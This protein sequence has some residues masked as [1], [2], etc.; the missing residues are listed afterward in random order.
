MLCRQMQYRSESS[1]KS[2]F[3]PSIGYNGQF[4][5]TLVSAA[6]M[7]ALRYFLPAAALVVIAF[8][9]R[10]ACG[11]EPVFPVDDAYITAHNAQVLHWGHDPNFVGTPALAGATSPFHLA[12]VA[13]L[14]YF[15][16][17]LWAIDFT[18]WLGVLL[19]ALG[20][21]RLAWSQGV[22][23][24]ASALLVVAGLL[25]ART[26]H[27]LMNGL[28]TGW[29]IAAVTWVLALESS[30]RRS[31]T[32]AFSALCGMLP[33]LRPELVAL[34][35]LLLPMPALRVWQQARNTRAS[36]VLLGKCAL[37]ALVAMSPWLVWQFAATGHLVP[38]TIAAK[39]YFFAESAV[40]ADIKWLWVKGSTIYF[41][42]SCGPLAFAC[43]ALPFTRI[44]KAALLF[45][46]VFL[47]AYYMLFPGAL[48]HAQGRYLYILL[49]FLL[50]G[51][52]SL[53]RLLSDRP[54]PR[55]WA[56][57]YVM[58]AAVQAALLAP[59]TWREHQAEQINTRRELVGV[60]DWC[61][62]HI[63]A[64]SRLLIHDAGYISYATS[65]HMV[66][67]VGLKSPENIDLHRT[68]TYESGGASRAAAVNEAAIRA[69]ADYFIV[70][71]LWDGLYKLTDGLRQYGWTL[72]PVR[73]TGT[74]RV[75]RMSRGPCLMS[76]GREVRMSLGGGPVVGG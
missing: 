38:A 76:G 31:E 45:T 28:E 9:V 71:D 11:W 18:A 7:P 17:P 1:V 47:A 5:S 57:I 44:G 30:K 51:A 68:L 40:S 15:V 60:A 48:C 34:S 65:F 73:T 56:T 70:L 21:A 25:A 50:F 49:P 20:I 54:A 13:L 39:R 2:Y 62:A 42:C 66:D 8:A 6:T 32:F 26:P 53:F 23:P 72:E 69:N 22:P 10:L 63:P 4:T 64:G 14:M 59:F 16:S 67:I 19:F 41:L 12:L 36:L 52:A 29:A 37:T 43:L 35:L 33:M 27:Q 58:A 24:A 3:N 75:Y 55:R 46:A 61:N 74:Y